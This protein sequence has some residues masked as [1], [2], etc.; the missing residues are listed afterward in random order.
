MNE[1]NDVVV[2]R[3]LDR[4]YQIKCPPEKIA[5]LQEAANYLDLQ[6]RQSQDSSKLIGL[7]RI[8]MIAALNIANELIS[9]KRQKHTYID[10]MSLRIQAIQNK[11]EEAL[12]T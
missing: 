9:S 3:L 7:D 1:L 6:M 12:A 5:D 8:L 4:E 10:N 11:I 2:I